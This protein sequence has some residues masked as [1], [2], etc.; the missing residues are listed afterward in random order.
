[1]ENPDEALDHAPAGDQVDAVPS[2][3]F[4]VY[5]TEDGRTEVQLRTV[6]GTVWLTQRQIADLFDKSVPTINEH[7]KAI[8]DDGECVMEATIRK[9]RMVRAEGARVVEREIDHYNLDVIL[10]VGYRV[11]SP[12]GTQFRRWATTVLREYLIKGFAMNDARLKDPRGADY[13][14]ELLER[15]R[16]IRAS[17]KRFYEKVREVFAASSADYDPKSQVAQTFFATIQNKL[18]YAVTQHTAAEL[19]V[20]RSDPDKQNMGLTTFKGAVVRKCDVSIAKNYLTEDEVKRLNRLTTMFLDFAEDRAENRQQLV[21][22]DW[23]SQT[24]R[25]LQFNER[26]VLQG[27]GRVSKADAAQISSE[28]YAKFD[29]RR[30]TIEE[31]AADLAELEAIQNEIE[32]RK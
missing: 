4:I 10:A 11:R 28:R 32:K 18:L 19:V 17:E 21:M 31:S 29:A 6:D 14:D 12:R 5:N 22:A 16:D 2:G 13:F 24:D 9:F 27:P 20:A 8:Y 7:I 15:I 23:V 26:S 30:R 1:M 3:E 25:F